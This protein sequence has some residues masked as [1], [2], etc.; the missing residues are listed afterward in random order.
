MAEQYDFIIVG[1]GSAGCVL[2]NRLSENGRYQVL[3]LEAGGSDMRFW[4]QVPIGYGLIYEDERV[5]WKYNTKADPGINGRSE[6]WPRGKVV[7]G[8]SSINAM[9]YIRGQGEDYD[10]WEA[11]GNPGWGYRDVLPWFIKSEN[12]ELGESQYHGTFGPLG[13]S[14]FTPH[15]INKTFFKAGEEM[16][17]PYNEDFNG[18]VQEG[19]GPYQLTTKD[20]RRCSASRA[21]L[22]PALKR[23]NL[24][25]E[26]N[27]QATRILFEGKRATG[28]EYEQ[29]GKRIRAMAG[30]EVILSGGSIGSPQLL[31]LSGV[32][33][34]G[35][36][37]KHNIDVV[38]DRTPVGQN[39]QDHLFFS[40]I[41]K[42]NAP[43]LNNELHSPLGKL[44]AGMKYVFTRTGPLSLSINHGGGFIRTD[45]QMSRPNIQLYLVPASFTEA[46]LKNVDSFAGAAINFSPC[47]P[48]SRGHLEIQ[49]PDF[50]DHPAIHPNYLSTDHD[51]AE[52]LAG[53][54]Y[55]HKLARTPALSGLI[56][57]PIQP[58][59]HEDDG[60]ALLDRLR[61][62]GS[63][64]YHP[65][66]TCL[67]G[68]DPEGAVVDHRLKVY[69][70]EG[71]RV[72]DASIMP[73][74]I[75]GNTNAPSIMIGERGADFILDDQKNS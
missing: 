38:A 40:Y 16:G 44:W 58:W 9:V 35:L 6:Y 31:Q 28:V 14:S 33:D 59:P 70:L 45:P 13:V 37:K 20:G 12:N 25:L 1:A 3:I 36:L 68:P 65:I 60:E 56:R 71:L 47:R 75:S 8:S 74:M 17:V 53:A 2:A 48:T 21:F 67:M 61:E 49:S 7:G 64:T 22:R 19:F 63:T 46:S 11:A 43:T 55:V 51:V 24:N 5:N 15:P 29:N 62:I 54:R 52:A 10:D 69:G 18:A 4:V 66:G 72:V 73:M 32:G 41:F 34:A 23:P 30:R 39:L 50:R 26:K 57:E 27:A 42:T